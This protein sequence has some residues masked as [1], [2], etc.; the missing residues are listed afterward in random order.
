MNIRHVLN[1]ILRS[2]LLGLNLILM[3][4]SRSRRFSVIAAQRIV[5]LFLLLLLMVI[6]VAAQ[7]GGKAAPNQAA[8]APAGSYSLSG[9]DNV[10]LY[11][12]NLN[13]SLPLLKVGGRG[14]AQ[15]PIN[16]NINSMRWQVNRD[17]FGGTMPPSMGNLTAVITWYAGDTFNSMPASGYLWWM[18]FN[19]V[20]AESHPMFIVNG[21][22]IT[23]VPGPTGAGNIYYS[24]GP[25]EL[26][27]VNSGYG[28]GIMQQ[29]TAN[30]GGGM[31]AP[32]YYVGSALTR[33]VFTAPDGTEYELIDQKTGGIVRSGASQ[34]PFNRG[35][36]FASRDGSNI[37]FESETDIIEYFSRDEVQ[38][39]IADPGPTG[40][41]TFPD[42][43]KYRIRH[44]L[45]DWMRDR[46]GNTITFTYGTDPNNE[47]TYKQV[48]TTTDS[49]GRVVS[50][51]YKVIDSA[52]NSTFDRINYK[53]WNAATGSLEDRAIKIWRGRLRDAL[54]EGYTIGT[55][56]SLFSAYEQ[57]P[58]ITETAYNPEN[59]ATAV[60]LPD[61]RRYQLRYNP[62][63]EIAQVTLPTGGVVEYDYQMTMTGT[64]V[65]R[66]LI[67]RRVY[68]NN[69][70][71]IPEL[72]QTY[73]AAYSPT[74]TGFNAVN[75][76]VVVQQNGNF[77]QTKEKHHFHGSATAI[78]WGFYSPWR[79]GLEYQ[80]DTYASD[81]TTLLRSVRT[82]WDQRAPVS[83]YQN[84]PDTSPPNFPRVKSVTTE[85]HDVPGGAI[86]ARKMFGYDESN[87]FNN[88]TD[89]W[90]YAF[91]ASDP[92][93]TPTPGD[94]LLRHTQTAYL[95]TGSTGGPTPTPTP[96]STPDPSP[97]PTPPEGCRC[98]NRT[99]SSG[100]SAEEYFR[101][102]LVRLPAEVLIY[103]VVNNQEQLKAR[104]EYIY[105]ETTLLPRVGISGW[106]EPG[107]L[108]RGNA[109]TTKRWINPADNNAFAAGKAKYDQAGNV[110]ETTDANNKVTSIQFEDC[111]GFADGNARACGSR[112]TYAL[113]TSVTNA[114]GHTAYAKY[115]Y[116]SG[117]P[118]TTED[119]N[120]VNTNMF[121]NDPLGRITQVVSAAGTTLQ[122]QSSFIYNDTARRITTKSDLSA[123]NDNKLKS[124]TLYDGLGRATETHT[125]E[126]S[127]NFVTAKQFYDG[128]GRVVRAT[129]PYRA[130]SDPTYGEVESRYDALGRVTEVRTTSDDA[131]LLT[132]YTGNTITVTDQAG[133]QRKSVMD[134]LGRLVKVFEAP[135]FADYNYETRYQYDALG[136]LTKVI[137]GPQDGNNDQIR[138][139]VYDGLSRLTSSTNPESGS[140]T[141][142]GGTISYQYDPNGNLVEK[143]S[144]RLG[145]DQITHYRIYYYYDALNRLTRRIYNDGTP[146]VN[147]FYDAQTLPAGAPVLERG[148]SIG[149]LLGVTCGGSSDINGAYYGYDTTSRTVKSVQVTDGQSFTM[150]YGY[151]LS[152]KLTR[153]KYPSGREV[154]TAYDEVG[155]LDSVS[156]QKAG[157]G[158]KTY[159][160]SPDYTAHGGIT[161]LKLGNGLWERTSFNSR[162][163][164]VE[165][166]LGTQ[167]NPQSVLQLDYSYGTADNNGNVRNQT[168]SVPGL[169]TLTQTYTYD[170]VNRLQVAKET[171]GASPWQQYFG[172]DRYGNRRFIPEGT[173][174]PA[175]LGDPNNQP[176]LNPK[177]S[178]ANNRLFG[179]RYDLAGNVTIDVTNRTYDYDGDNRLVRF[180]GG[181][182]PSTGGADYVYDGDGKRIKKVTV[183]GTTV[184][185]Y[186]AGGQLVAEYTTAA[187]ERNG[188]SY[189]T[190]DTLGTPRVITKTN[191]TLRSRHDYLPFGEELYAEVGGRTGWQGY[192]QDTVR[193]KFTEY[194]RDHESGLDYAKARYYSSAHGRFMS[195]DSIAFSSKANPQSLNLYAYTANNPLNLTDPT[196]H[197]PQ[198]DKGK[199]QSV[200]L[201]EA[202]SCWPACSLPPGHKPI[203]NETVNVIANVETTI[204]E[205]NNPVLSQLP[206]S[207]GSFVGSGIEQTGEDFRP[208]ITTGLD[209]VSVGGVPI[210]AHLNFIR[211]MEDLFGQDILADGIQAN[212]SVFGAG[213]SVSVSRNGTFLFGGEGNIGE[214]FK[215]LFVDFP[216]SLPK[217][218]GSN[219]RL[220]SGGVTGLKIIGQGRLGSRERT[221]I[222]GG[223]S[224]NM[225]G[226][227]SG[228]TGTFQVNQD[229]KKVIGIGRGSSGVNFGASVSKEGF[230][231]PFNLW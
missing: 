185:V 186:D 96:G 87:S 62:Y 198:D 88:Q 115:D 202:P 164:L 46:N 200:Q 183:G 102:N 25:S 176:F 156:G 226:G 72:T 114:L 215:N 170:G 188:T 66:R 73:T 95:L 222:L 105:D 101:Q 111:F 197:S 36:S 133:K 173:S 92:S 84:S 158:A 23:N 93:G 172:Y 128:L 47:A 53:A 113:P 108:A 224:F 137:Q 79:D 120:G 82:L 38:P 21:L 83:W 219:V 40:Y 191:G 227:A 145:N 63:N 75:T 123:F 192:V 27:K 42:G 2:L 206:L 195:P 228:W 6:S 29:R 121:Y 179:Y 78:Q 142:P 184:F 26:Q 35:K 77:P 140:S 49:L 15:L 159:V 44:G 97:S 194:E 51:D 126:R 207:L 231:L 135:N 76:T 134:A 81:G 213:G 141:D 11:N 37:I 65:Y 209:P 161:A 19:P 160:S 24:F 163:Q 32:A 175:G 39:V 64:S 182:N 166:K 110:I 169:N 68:K 187:A 74:N 18:D 124:E 212:G 129:N 4:S 34:F 130:T 112:Q 153:Q 193:Q 167:T 225:G 8:G 131:N 116:Y 214:T 216:G 85:L 13:F 125:Y 223:T 67:E 162:L 30:R 203:L 119:A 117:T 229:G 178:P 211:R 31:M 99:G 144:P 55:F 54:R 80:T 100:A 210:F 165:I 148:A 127:S 43:T 151:D 10:N 14:E 48:L 50:V 122:R 217:G 1:N 61:G 171:G 56:G 90:E 7:I 149:K 150:E 3:A 41:L 146:E 230:T 16:L 12:G 147:Y 22:P 59:V 139:F 155:R 91:G 109:T 106:T 152:D 189:L 107:S 104:T 181:A 45:V 5:W 33:I 143:I 199:P 103:D 58:A 174:L 9:F 94:T 154:T 86:A 220:F 52:T 221:N 69:L 180:N 208:T 71:R 204:V 136:N 70:A 98:N 205:E 218:G 196:G 190:S 157:E 60:E 201:G 89:V 17:T 132:V 168:I 28:P 138:S 118:V 20:N 177:I 57:A